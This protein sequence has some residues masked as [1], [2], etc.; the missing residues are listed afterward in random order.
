M[1]VS[2]ES[3]LTGSIGSFTDNWQFNLVEQV[4]C[5]IYVSGIGK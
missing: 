4:K 5:I 3:I 2:Q 1:F